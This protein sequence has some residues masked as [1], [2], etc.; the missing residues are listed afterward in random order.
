MEPDYTT[1]AF[2]NPTGE[3]FTGFWGGKPYTIQG[4]ETKNY[5]MFLAKHLA[6]HLIDRIIGTGNPQL[7]DE[8]RRAEVEKTILGEV[9]MEDEPKEKLSE[10]EKVARKVAEIEKKVKASAEPFAEL[11]ETK[12]KKKA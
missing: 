9:V 1:I 10:G 4:G 3:D 8:A 2:T 11:K 7:R 5:P 6:K 12:T